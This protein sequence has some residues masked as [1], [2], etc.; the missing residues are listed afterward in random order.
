M[1]MFDNLRCEYPLPVP[2]ANER[3]Y[4]TKDTPSQFLATYFITK[5]GKLTHIEP[6]WEE[7]DPGD[8]TT[9]KAYKDDDFTGEIRFYDCDREG[10]NWLEFSA[11]F[12]KGDLK[13]IGLVKD[14]ANEG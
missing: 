2:G 12:W 8:L 7:Y 11:Y 14:E 13:H 9:L 1:G 3:E 6:H 4:Q 10:K 5:D